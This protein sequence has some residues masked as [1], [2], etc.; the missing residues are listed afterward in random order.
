MATNEWIPKYEYKSKK[1]TTPKFD[2][3]KYIEKINK[4]SSTSE[5]YFGDQL[6]PKVSEPLNL[7]KTIS[8]EPLPLNIR[9]SKIDDEEYDKFNLLDKTK[10]N[11]LHS[12]LLP[13]SVSDENK[14]NTKEYWDSQNTPHRAA[15]E[16]FLDSTTL[17]LSK[18]IDRGISKFRGVDSEFDESQEEN[19]LAYGA[20]KMGGYILPF[21]KAKTVAAPLTNTLTKG[22]GNQVAKRT[23]SDALIGAG[24]DTV[25]G[26]NEGARGKELS[27]YVGEGAA[28]GIGADLGLYGVGK[29]GSAIAKKLTPVI[30][31]K[32]DIPN[33]KQLN[34]SKTDLNIS[35]PGKSVKTEIKTPIET[36]LPKV[37]QPKVIAMAERD[38]DN[39]ADKTVR[40][41]QKD[42]PEVQKHI[43]N[44]A[45]ILKG[46]LETVVKGEK[47][48]IRDELGYAIG[49]NS[50][51]RQA[52][53]TVELIRDITGK[54]YDQINKAVDNIIK[55]NVND[56]NFLAKKIELLL[57]DR[58]SNG[59]RDS[60]TGLD[61]PAV[62]DYI[63]VKGGNLEV[64]PDMDFTKINDAA[65][66]ETRISSL[67]ESISKETN[68]NTIRQMNLQLFGA[69]ERLKEI[70]K[71]KTNTLKNS[72]HLDTEEAQ[73][74]VNE[75]T[76]QYNVKPNEAMVEKMTYELKHDFDDIVERIK[77]ADSLSSAE[78]SVAAGLITKQ[79]RIDAEKTGDYLQLKEWLETVQPKVTNTA[80]SLQALKTWKDMSPEG[81]LTKAQQ[82]VDQ[83]N[84]DGKKTFGDNF[85]K[86]EFAPEELKQITDDMKVINEM[87]EGK[88]KEREFAKVKQQISDKIPATLADKIKA[89]Q[90]I[91]L[92]LN[93]KTNIRNVAG[94][95]ILTTLE[96][97]KDIP[98]TAIDKLASLKTGK[99]T[100]LL[101]SIKGIETQ[102]KGGRKGV[103]TV[104][105]D[106]KEGVNT[107]QSVGQFDIT[108]ERI[109][110]NPVLNKLE[111]TTDTALRFGD[112]PFYQAAYDETLRQQMKIN[113]VDKPT[114]EMEEMAKEMAEERTLQNASY[115]ADA[116]K[117]I[118]KHINQLTG[119]KD[120]GIGTFAVPFVKTPANIL[121]K[122]LDYSPI[123]SLKAI[124]Q[125]I[126][127]KTFNQKQFVDRVGRS[128]VG[129]GIIALG[130]NLA[131]KG[132]I[133]GKGNKD[134][135][136]ATL[137][138]QTGK[139]PYSFKVGDTYN[140]FDW[141]QPASTPLAIGAD[142]F[143]EGKTDAQLKDII[144]DAFKSGG[145][146]LMKQSLLQGIQRLFGGY[147]AL[148]G[149][150]STVQ[151]IPTQFA[152]T[153]MK[154]IA[155]LTDSKL[156]DSYS[157]T[158]LGT[159]GNKLKAKTPGLSKTLEPRLDT[160]GR[161]IEQFQGKNNPFN[162]LVNP[163][164]TTKE[165][166]N[167]TEKL[168]LDIYNQTGNKTHFPR[169]AKKEIT[170][171]KDAKNNKTITL[172]AKEKYT[173]QKYIGQETDEKFQQLSKRSSFK[174]MSAD[175]QAKQLQK[176]LTEIYNEG[177]EIILKGRKI[178]EY[179]KW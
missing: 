106:I 141:A 62:N 85:D 130:Y 149:I 30:R 78:D 111:R 11:L 51:N 158:K 27:K 25:Q 76:A 57:D 164:F 123:G 104:L 8:H 41:L 93:P 132:V 45:Q 15:M 21:Q 89:L 179:K 54:D 49:T 13:Q 160:L 68:E 148:G 71:F 163:G 103:E 53:E 81:V 117:G 10:V 5:G 100:T 65:E 58:L 3:S 84:R 72:K 176:L 110:K 169:T 156:R 105:G 147:T 28:M 48:V 139:S 17:G 124:G 128:V 146:T 171:K 118:Q 70:S 175:A 40:S 174:S 91:S 140:T 75:I 101:P 63:S 79:Y 113:K 127:K 60:Y 52:S 99:R 66:L 33:L 133:V 143:Q 138:R 2:S 34:D 172:T 46:E 92:L 24:L 152:P 155:Q 173:L 144:V 177:E 7:K 36:D 167:S 31:N 97:V 129:T 16:G 159:L 168:V 6:L 20:G 44:E 73:K 161:E 9:T 142:I 135:D 151:N 115:M 50:T 102:L 80:Q 120:L 64:K 112:E 116:F 12:K 1:K 67:E 38:F 108:G 170:Y 162:V 153:A 166:T 95:T 107:S 29:L 32:A 26:F 178:I 121:D 55:G 90:R 18:A 157:D 14:K 56:N 150:E 134:R 83:V 114:K 23:V 131:K 87:P 69:E 4:G 154:Q 136:V 19:P 37:K 122:A 22:I 126:S 61:I 74:V 165:K 35:E 82:V 98:G 119:N 43:Q 125:L 94:N 77:K 96:N 59:Y 47:M 39:V 88:A 42:F 109:F 137:E 145:E 86:V